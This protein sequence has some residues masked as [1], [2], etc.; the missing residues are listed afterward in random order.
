MD[1]KSFIQLSA[2]RVKDL[3]FQT[4]DEFIFIVNGKEFKTTRIISDLISPKICQLH[5]NDPTISQYTMK[6]KHKGS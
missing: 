3:P 6:T 5:L 2:S 4:Y 1:D